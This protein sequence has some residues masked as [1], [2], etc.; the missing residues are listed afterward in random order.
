MLVGVRLSTDSDASLRAHGPHEPDTINAMLGRGRQPRLA[1]VA[2]SALVIAGLLDAGAGRRGPATGRA[3][4]LQQR[5]EPLPEV[6]VRRPRLRC[7]LQRRAGDCRRPRLRGLGGG[8]R[9]PSLPQRRLQ[10]GGAAELR[11]G[12]RRSP[13]G[14]AGSRSS[15][16]TTCAACRATSP[17]TP[18]P[19]TARCRRSSSRSTAP[20]LPS[21]T[22]YGM[23]FDYQRGADLVDPQADAGH[24]GAPGRERPLEQPRVHSQQMGDPPPR[25]QPRPQPRCRRYACR[26]P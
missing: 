20:G 9:Q 24:Q 15:T 11:A 13:C 19:A 4:E 12:L 2:S 25:R 3:G 10:P 23:I 1:L 7:P 6:P 18:S 22:R 5:P 14:R 26:F 17:N 8:D 21:P 16:A